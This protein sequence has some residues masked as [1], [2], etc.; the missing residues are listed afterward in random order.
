MWERRDS[1][2][3]TNHSTVT[4]KQEILSQTELREREREISPQVKVEEN[5]FYVS[6]S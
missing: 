1:G 6:K 4:G 2:L 3:Y 5:V